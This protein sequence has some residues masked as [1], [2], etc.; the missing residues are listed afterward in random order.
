MVTAGPEINLVVL[1]FIKLSCFTC[2]MGP[3]LVTQEVGNHWSRQFDTPYGKQCKRA[4]IVFVC[5]F[6]CLCV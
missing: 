3:R 2:L 6:V 1:N 5:L 4:I